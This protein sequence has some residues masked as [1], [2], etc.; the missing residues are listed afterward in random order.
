MYLGLNDFDYT[1]SDD[2]QFDF[3]TL[4]PD[5]Y[6]TFLTTGSKG[7]LRAWMSAKVIFAPRA[8]VVSRRSES[9]SLPSLPAGARL[10]ATI[11]NLDLLLTLT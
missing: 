3:N 4:L 5:F 6:G 10:V 9:L 1:L 8:K 11:W 2:Q 7:E